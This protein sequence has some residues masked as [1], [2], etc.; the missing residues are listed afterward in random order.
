MK[1]NK[2]AQAALEFLTTYGWAFLVILVMIGALAY[3]GILNPKTLL[4][5]RCTI[6][7]EFSCI[8]HVINYGTGADDVSVRLLLKSSN[9]GSVSIDAGDFSILAEGGS[10]IA[11]TTKTIDGA[12]SV[13]GWKT[14]DQK[15]MLFSGCDT[16]DSKLSD[17]DKGK[18][19][20]SII[21]YPVESGTNFKKEINGEI[22][23]KVN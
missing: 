19:E 11:C 6:G 21:L 15:V 12:A 9:T 5:N 7:P 14:A 23:S 20:L 13:S 16:S 17:G 3:F 18:I 1:Y 4:P 2:K 10:A 8:D 22:F